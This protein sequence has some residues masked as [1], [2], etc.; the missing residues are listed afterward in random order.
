MERFDHH[1]G[2]TFYF[3]GF[4]VTVAHARAG[5]LI[6]YIG[7]GECETAEDTKRVASLLRKKLDRDVGKAQNTDS[8]VE[9][10]GSSLGS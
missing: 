10:S 5:R 7:S 2:E 6:A 8:S 3:G 9:Q 4:P 1:E